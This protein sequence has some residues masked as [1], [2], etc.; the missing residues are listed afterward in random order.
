MA[1]RTG[2]TAKA[3]CQVA[4]ARGAS[5]V[6]L[7]VPISGRDIFARF[8]VRRRGGL[9]THARVLLCR[10]SG[11]CNFAQTSDDEVIAL[12]DRALD[13]FREAAAAAT[14]DDPPIRD[15]EVRVSAG[16]CRWPDI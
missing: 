4:R 1:S 10:R 6:V 3:A 11:Y 9:L 14:S 5:K 12:L 8:P 16:R 13:G 15:E 2:A 7:A